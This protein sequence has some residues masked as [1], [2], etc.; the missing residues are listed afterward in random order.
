MPGNI[1]AFKLLSAWSLPQISRLCAARQQNSRLKLCNV[2]FWSLE[3]AALHAQLLLSYRRVVLLWSGPQKDETCDLCG[4]VNAS[5]G[6]HNLLD[7]GGATAL[8]RLVITSLWLH[9]L[10]RCPSELAGAVLGHRP[11]EQLQ[12]PRLDHSSV[13]RG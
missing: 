7:W 10:A 3:N 6:L 11:T 13:C 5:F 4:C 2:V 12:D 1:E 9:L 8:L